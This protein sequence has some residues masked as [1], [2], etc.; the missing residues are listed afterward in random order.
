M[1]MMISYYE[2]IRR[3]LRWVTIGL[4]SHY[5]CDHWMGFRERMSRQKNW[6]L[7]DAAVWLWKKWC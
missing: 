6:F 5:K 4:N 2:N 3:L 1:K 7:K